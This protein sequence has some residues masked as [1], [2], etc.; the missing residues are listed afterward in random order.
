MP[1]KDDTAC[2]FTLDVR[3]DDA[4]CAPRPCVKD[5]FTFVKI[6]F[7]KTKFRNYCL[8]FKLRNGNRFSC[9]FANQKSRSMTPY[10]VYAEDDED[11][12]QDMKRMIA[13]IDPSLPVHIF[14]N[15][16]ELI[17]YLTGLKNN[18]DKPSL[19]FL[20][21]NMPI[22]DGIRTLQTLKSDAHFNHIPVIMWSTSTLQRDID[23]AHRLGAAAFI[24]KP[25]HHDEW[26][27]VKGELMSVHLSPLFVK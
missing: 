3:A 4:G 11:D 20:D 26:V 5:R 19:I 27:K 9:I 14:N 6:P 18:E 23:L 24:T 15:G 1:W 16:L 21:V 13:D 12:Q 10:I 25:I 8:T 2:A 7:I 17:Q 22:W